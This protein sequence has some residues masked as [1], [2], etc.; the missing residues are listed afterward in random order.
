MFEVQQH[1]TAVRRGLPGASVVGAVALVLLLSGCTRDDL[2]TPFYVS[3]VAVT[4]GDFDNVKEPLNRMVVDSA[5]YEGIISTATW[6]PSYEH[7]N[8]A[9][10]VE[11]LLGND[12]EIQNHTA[13]FIASGTRGLGKRQ[14]NGL[15]SDDHLVSSDLV[16]DNV[17]NYVDGETVLFVTDWG[18]DLIEAVWPDMIDFLNDDGTY[19]DAQH[20]EIGRITADIVDPDLADA[21]GV[22]EMGIRFNY[23]NW[24]VITGVDSDAT[25]LIRGTIEYRPQTGGLVETLEDV[26]L[27]VGFQPP[28]GRGKV[29][30]T[31]FHLDAQNDQLIDD[32][33]VATVGTFEP[34]EGE[35]VAT[36]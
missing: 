26:P 24:A 11:H 22:D 25:V 7:E 31:A 34:P 28:G 36:E 5:T 23:S 10:K 8:V 15:E 6:D 20:G 16:I 9:L 2:F 1:R 21:L 19:D 32:L 30:F 13:T 29:L 18:Y 4:A 14:Y 33:I 3:S 35:A 12:N 27:M 17:E